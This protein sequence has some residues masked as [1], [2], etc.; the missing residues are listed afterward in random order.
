MQDN[1]TTNNRTK[2]PLGIS[3]DQTNVPLDV[4][5]NYEMLSKKI[6]LPTFNDHRALKS[7]FDQNPGA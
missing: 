6:A 1:V 2:L 4:Y 5:I 7:S 3:D